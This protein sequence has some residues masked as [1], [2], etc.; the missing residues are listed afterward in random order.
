MFLY[1][2]LLFFNYLQRVT[3]GVI[4]AT[5]IQNDIILTLSHGEDET[6]AA[7]LTSQIEKMPKGHDFHY[8]ADNGIKKGITSSLCSGVIENQL[9]PLPGFS[10]LN[11]G[12][13]ILKFTLPDSSGIKNVFWAC[14]PWRGNDFSLIHADG[15]AGII[16][17]T[18]IDNITHGAITVARVQDSIILLLS[19]AE[20]ETCAAGL[21]SETQGMPKGHNFIYH[22]DSG[23]KLATTGL[24]QNG[25]VSNHAAIYLDSDFTEMLNTKILKITLPDSSGIKNIFWACGPWRN[26]NF[27]NAHGAN[28]GIIQSTDMDYVAPGIVT[29]RRVQDYIILLLSHAEGE[30]CAAGLTSETQGMPKG[31]DFM[32]HTDSGTKFATTSLIGH[33]VIFNQVNSLVGTTEVLSTK[34]LKLTLRNT[35]RVKNVF[36][37]CGP[38]GIIEND[39]GR[40]HTSDPNLRGIIQSGDIIVS[41]SP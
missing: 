26:D 40:I 6:C 18:D 32:Y 21:T 38:S 29:A 35:T 7:G 23:T 5:R 28:R 33:Y 36:W 2:I 19:H 24:N 13:N 34:V 12:A 30:T 4:K 1:R 25:L 22:T 31:H 39:F 15:S 9:D 37:A 10:I 20:G 14:G 17:S 16:Q 11:P 3:G 41:G 27:N 8:F